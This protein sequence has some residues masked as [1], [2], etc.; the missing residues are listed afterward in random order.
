MSTLPLPDSTFQDLQ[1]PRSDSSTQADLINYSPSHSD[2]AIQA[3]IPDNNLY[4]T[5]GKF[6]FTENHRW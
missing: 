5:V 2:V 4:Q 1:L 6:S 3:E